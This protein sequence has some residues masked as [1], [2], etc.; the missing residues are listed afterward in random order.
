VSRKNLDESINDYIRKSNKN[1]PLVTGWVVVASLAP[2]SGNTGTVDS[3]VTIS[4]DGLPVHSQVGLLEV[5]LADVKN[6]GLI[7]LI[8][9]F[10]G[11]G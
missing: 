4:S 1:A 3:Y 10:M 11:K 5:S 6:L 8:S 2:P 7:S 9:R